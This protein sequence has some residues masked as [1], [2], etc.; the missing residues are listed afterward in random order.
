MNRQLFLVGILASTFLATVLLI[1]RA[2]YRKYLLYGLVLGGLADIVV[3]GLCNRVLHWFT[4][5]SL[6][7]ANV[8]GW[9]ALVPLSF[10]FWLMLYLYFLPLRTAFLIPYVIAFTGMGIIMGQVTR[11]LGLFSY[12]P[13]FVYLSPFIFLAWFSAAAWVFRWQERVI[14]E[15]PV[16]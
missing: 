9:N 14:E 5:T 1:P 15:R 10:T 7:P 12:K 13:F 2:L 4:W 11:N 3:V 6:G 16:R 8:F